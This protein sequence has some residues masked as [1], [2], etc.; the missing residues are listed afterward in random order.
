MCLTVVAGLPRTGLDAADMDEIRA[1]IVGVTVAD[2]AAAEPEP[3]PEA[4]ALPA[5]DGA[6]A[7]AT[8]SVP[9]KNDYAL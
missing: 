8:P 9:E 6:T 2:G 5:H 4:G 1:F 7:S 3:E